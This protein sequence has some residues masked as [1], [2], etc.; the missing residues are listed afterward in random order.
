MIRRTI[1]V[2]GALTVSAISAFANGVAE[3]SGTTFT[4]QL[5]APSSNSSLL[6]MFAIL[7][8]GAIF[9]VS[10]RRSQANSERDRRVPA[11]SKHASL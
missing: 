4:Q 9:L 11:S 2:A 3:M 7:F 5:H 10:M 1:S 6:P 8:V